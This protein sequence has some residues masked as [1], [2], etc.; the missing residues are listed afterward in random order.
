MTL[1][2]HIALCVLLTVIAGGCSRPPSPPITVEA[3]DVATL[4]DPVEGL[5]LATIVGCNGCHGK[6]GGGKVL[7]E[8]K[9][10]TGQLHQT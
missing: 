4:G 2:M 7:T 3:P 8:K 1:L 9:V 6:N 5:R 10:H